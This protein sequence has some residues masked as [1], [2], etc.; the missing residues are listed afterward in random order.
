[1]SNIYLDREEASKI[2]KV[3]TR[4][5]DRYIRKYK[6][7]TRKQ[8]RTILIR[9][10][11]VDKIINDHIGHFIDDFNKLKEGESPSIMDTKVD[12]VD[13]LSTMSKIEDTI[14]VKDIKVK[15]IKPGEETVYKELYIE[16]KKEFREKQDRLEAATYRVGQLESQLKSTVP[17]LDYSRKEREL[18]EAQ[19]AM[20]QRHAEAKVTIEKIESKLRSER[21]AKWIYLSLVGLL[22]IAEPILFM[23]WAFA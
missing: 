18:K 4:T 7:K 5:L 6:I 20:E 10:A 8:G 17:L 11:D 22:L 14:E 16:L 23:M 21:V 13:A 9:R 19:A 1:M 15:N 2:L 3:S 12:N